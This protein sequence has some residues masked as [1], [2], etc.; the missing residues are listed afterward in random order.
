MPQE[1]I[2]DAGKGVLWRTVRRDKVAY[3]D[4]RYPNTCYM[5]KNGEISKENTMPQ[6]ATGDVGKGKCVLR[7]RDSRDEVLKKMD[8]SALNIWTIKERL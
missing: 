3:K 1:A 8:A 2:G 6:G 5:D 7:R 4:N